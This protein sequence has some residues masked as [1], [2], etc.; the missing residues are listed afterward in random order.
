MSAMA[1]VTNRDPNVGGVVDGTLLSA[2]PNDD[3]GA[4]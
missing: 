4:A 3:G 1:T 2:L